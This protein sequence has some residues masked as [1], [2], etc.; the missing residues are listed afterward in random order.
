MSIYCVLIRK[1]IISFC[2]LQKSASLGCTSGDVF[3]I[4][5]LRNV[6]MSIDDVYCMCELDVWINAIITKYL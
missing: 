1:T 4:T 3:I 2:V 5:L 6:S